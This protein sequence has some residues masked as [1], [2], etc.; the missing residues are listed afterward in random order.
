VKSRPRSAPAARR[1]EITDKVSR[2]FH[3]DVPDALWFT[4]ITQIRTAEGWLYAAVILD[5][6]NREVP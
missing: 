4:D 3:A 2:D 6:F 5:A 1:P